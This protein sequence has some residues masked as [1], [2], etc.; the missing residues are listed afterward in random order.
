M[1]RNETPDER[2]ERLKESIDFATWA[3]VKQGDY[4]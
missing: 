1:T 3:A 4:A 2:A